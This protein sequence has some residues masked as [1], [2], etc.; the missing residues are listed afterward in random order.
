MNKIIESFLETHKQE[1]GI[2]KYANDM[3]FEHFVNRCIVNKYSAERF[4]PSDIM[5]DPGEQGIDGVAICVNGRVV[6]S[7][8]EL[9]SIKKEAKILEV[10]FVFTQAKT[11]NNFDGEEIGTFLFGV[12][13]FF[14]DQEDRPKTND[15]M[16]QLIALKDKIYEYSVDM[17]VAPVLDMYFVCCGKWDDGNGLISRINLDKKILE[18]S[19]NFS[20]VNFFPYDSEKII[21]AYKELKKKISRTITMEKKVAFPSIEG[22]KQAFLGLVRC[23]DFVKLLSD[24]DNNMLTN[25]FED[26]VRDFQGYNAVNNEIKKTLYDHSDQIRFGLLNNGITIVAKS[27]SVV[28]DMVEIYDYQIVNGC[29]TS[30]VLFE[31]RNTLID[32]SYIVVKLIEVLTDELSDRV[33][34]TTN[35]QTEV[36]SEAFIATK[37]FHKGLQDFYN[38]IDPAYRLY[39]ERRSKQYDLI[40]NVS[41]NKVITLT[42]QIQAYLAMFL[43][44]PHSTHRYYGELL[45]S[46]K[47]K[48]FLDADDYEPYFCSAYFSYYL[49]TQLRNSIDK[50]YK[51]FKFHLI[52]A[53]RAVIAGSTVVFGQKKQQQKI[54][55]KLWTVIK[56]EN[57][58]RRVLNTAIS[59]LDSAISSCKNIPAADR[60]RSREI[61]LAMIDCAEKSVS[62]TMCSSFL[63]KGDIVHC[64][65]TAVRD[66][67]VDVQIKTDDARNLG[68]IYISN[69]APKYIQD[70]HKEVKIGD[71]FQVRII[72]E[73]YYEKPWGW[74]L[75]KIL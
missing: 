16:E 6:T 46:Y 37:H 32:D 25:I 1:Y 71:I 47:N 21:T 41:K 50:K 24:N 11:S 8:D 34:Y 68:S 29:Q 12:R 2:Q 59:C 54:C 69:I 28:G 75:T 13:A 45:E 36:K 19:Q 15:K 39:Y 22:V 18:D 65:V 56:D 64:T 17:P 63:K 61:T 74:E 55:Q 62:A 10:K 51:K 53:M 14:A 9:D 30:Y 23:K 40:D 52:C 38:S 48:I 20:E 5:T 67:C 4:N 26:N 70:I 7:I 66:Y 73:D 35:R 60:H 31:N 49:D 58:M 27:I 44:E 72:N 42:Q 33:I 3:A 43:N 57:S